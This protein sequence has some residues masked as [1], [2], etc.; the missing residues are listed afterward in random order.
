M[1]SSLYSYFNFNLL[2]ILIIWL[3]TP[4]KLYFSFYLECGNDKIID[5]VN[6]TLNSL[7]NQNP[8]PSH[9]L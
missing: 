6:K 3:W 8:F 7:E 9:L 2:Y 1:S 5:I 4:S